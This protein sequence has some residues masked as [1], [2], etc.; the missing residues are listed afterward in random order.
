MPKPN[1]GGPAF[2]RPASEFTKNGSLSD[3][4]DAIYEQDGMSLRDAFAIA[5]LQGYLA[6]RNRE[7]SIN[8]PNDIVAGS[9]YK[10]ADA[11]LAEREKGES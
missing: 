7:P 5:A 11:M 3:G 1:D 6:G 8:I 9:C 4:N 10:Y 2:P